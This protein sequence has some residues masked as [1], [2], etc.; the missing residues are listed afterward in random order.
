MWKLKNM[1][2]LFIWCSCEARHI[3][4]V[5]ESDVLHVW[6]HVPWYLPK[7]RG[8]GLWGLGRF[9]LIIFFLGSQIL[10]VI[11]VIPQFRSH[12]RSVKPWKKIHQHPEADT[13]GWWRGNLEGVVI[14]APQLP[15]HLAP[16]LGR[17]VQVCKCAGD[18]EPLCSSYIYMGCASRLRPAFANLQ[19][20][21][22]K[23]LIFHDFF[24]QSFICWSKCCSP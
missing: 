10:P 20:F 7:F 15:S 24:L 14:L 21:I 6:M 18:L 13:N 1:T 11:P 4:D 23:G 19:L 22:K 8:V 5:K 16:Q 12:Q 17:R 9:F 2:N 3:L